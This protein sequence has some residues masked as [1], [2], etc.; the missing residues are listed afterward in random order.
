MSKIKALLAY[1]RRG[2]RVLL[3]ILG[4]ALVALLVAIVNALTGGFDA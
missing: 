3:W 4:I 2:D 1:A